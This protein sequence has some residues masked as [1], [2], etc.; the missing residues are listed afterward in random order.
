MSPACAQLSAVAQTGPSTVATALCNLSRG[1]LA[2]SLRRRRASCCSS[3]SISRVS[4]RGG[5]AATREPAMDHPLRPSQSRYAIA[6]PKHDDHTNSR[7]SGPAQ[8][9]RAP[10]SCQ[11]RAQARA[12]ARPAAKAG[13]GAAARAAARRKRRAAELAAAAERQ[14]RQPAP[15]APTAAA[16]AAARTGAVQRKWPR[17]GA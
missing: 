14:R 10:R 15:R 13:R 7:C 17:A 9:R 2:I 11:R 4:P 5:C 1:S 8:R 6:R 16:T 3:R 12:S